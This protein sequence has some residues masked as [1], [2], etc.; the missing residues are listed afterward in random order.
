MSFNRYKYKRNIYL[1]KFKY[2]DLWI[3]VCKLTQVNNE[4]KYEQLTNNNQNDLKTIFQQIGESIPIDIELIK[5]DSRCLII[6]TKNERYRFN[7]EYEY[8]NYTKEYGGKITL[9][10]IIIQC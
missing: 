7:W 10:N 8:I 5:S 2:R 6:I 3:T 4:W 1:D 9:P